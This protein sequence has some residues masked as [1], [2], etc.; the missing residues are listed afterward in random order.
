IV[1]EEHVAYIT[2]THLNFISKILSACKM[3]IADVAIV[4]HF[5]KP[6][7]IGELKKQLEPAVVLLFGPEPV[8]IKLPISFPQFKS[9]AYDGS[10]YLYSPSLNELAQDSEEGKLLKSKLWVC[11]RK[12]FEV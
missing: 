10:T 2:E 7:V 4:N 11:L 3:N 8:Q 6:V 9:Q 5:A 1:Q 12:I